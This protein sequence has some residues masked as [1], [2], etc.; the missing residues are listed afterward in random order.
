V[1]AGANL[2]LHFCHLAVDTDIAVPKFM[3]VYDEV[4]HIAPISMSLLQLSAFTSEEFPV[5]DSGE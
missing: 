5:H 4:H 1:T 3:K 2:Y